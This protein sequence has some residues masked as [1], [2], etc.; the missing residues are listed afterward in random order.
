MAK[1]KVNITLPSVDELFT[2]QEERDAQANPLVRNIPVAAISPFPDHPF[3]VRD[4]DD[5]HM[6][7]DSIKEHGVLVPLTVRAVGDDSYELIS[8]H[9]RKHAAETLGLEQLPCIVKEL[10]DD[11][12][13][14][15]MVDSNLQRETI[16]PSERAFAYSMRLEAMKHQGQRSDLTSAQ[17][18]QKL[19][20]KVSRDALAEELGVS[21]DK[22][23]RFIRLT[24]L[25]PELLKLVDEGRMKMMPAVEISFLNL[26]EQ[27]CLLD[28]ME[29]QACTPSHAQAKKLHKYSGNGELN[30]ALI[31]SIM[32]EEKPNQVAQFRIPKKKISRFFESDATDEEIERRIIKA[33]EL[34]NQAEARQNA[35]AKNG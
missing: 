29:A 24:N 10:T 4:D 18:A 7:T 28:A 21:K 8:G 2:S 5:M 22:I 32:E 1:K 34:L 26:K 31:Q 15:A 23:Q 16:L 9:R 27:K 20:K 13:I 12:A 11:E 3:A 30:P 33:L 14:I 25:I 6:L 17:L 19:D 35:E